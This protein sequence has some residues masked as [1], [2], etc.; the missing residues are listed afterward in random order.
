MKRNRIG[1]IRCGKSWPEVMPWRLHLKVVDPKR[2]IRS[3]DYQLDICHDICYT[4]VRWRWHMATAMIVDP[5]D[6]KEARH[7]LGFTQIQAGVA[8]GNV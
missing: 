3:N 8:L 4:A 1:G 2:S 6:V 7:I 5:I